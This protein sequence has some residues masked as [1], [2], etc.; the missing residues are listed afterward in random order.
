MKRPQYSIPP[1]PINHNSWARTDKQKATAFAEHFASVCQPSPS[2]LS[3]MEE[4]T[5]N[6]DLNAPHEMAAPMNKI[7]INEVKNVIQYKISPNKAPGY[8]L[9][10]GKILKELSQKGLRAI[11]QIYNAILQTDYFPCQWKVGQI[12]MI[13]KP[14]K[15]PNYITSYHPFSLLRAL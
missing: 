12:I 5:I 14:G 6:N 11:T 9:I 10:A 13:V 7:R 15:N 3:V 4:E 2:Q 1:I 8:N